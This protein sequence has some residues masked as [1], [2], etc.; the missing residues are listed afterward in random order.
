MKKLLNRFSGRILP[1]TLAVAMVS[2]PTVGNISASAK[3]NS[4]T[5]DSKKAE[6]LLSDIS[7]TYEELFPVLF[8]K[9]YNKYWTSSCEPFV[10]KANANAAAK[11]LKASVSGKKTGKKAI[12]YYKKKNTIAFNCNFTKK[13]KKITFKKNQITGKNAKGKVIFSHKYHFVGFNKTTGSYLYKSND[14]KSGE[15]TYFSIA[16]DTPKTTYHTE[17]RYGSS[18]KA[19]SQFTSG[20]YAYWNVGAIPVK[21]S[22]KLIKNVIQLFCE[23]NLTPDTSFFAGGKGTKSDPYRIANKK[24][25]EAFCKSVNDGS[26]YGYYGKYIKLTKDIDLNNTDW[27]PIGNMNDMKTHYTMFLGNFDGNNHTISNVKFT[28]AKDDIGAGL[29]GINCGTIQNLKVINANITSTGKN[30]M[31]IGGIVGYNMGGTLTNLTLFGNSSVTGN[32]CVGGIVG[33]ST[34]NITNATASSVTVTVIGNNDF[35]KGLV[36]CDIAECGGLI[37][38]GGFGGNIQNCTANG[39]IKATGNEPVG[40]GGIGGCLE[41]MDT[42][43]NCQ[44]TVS[45]DAPNGGH[46]IG[47]ICGYAGTHSNPKIAL[48]SEGVI[49]TK[50][51]SEISNCTANIQINANNATH[52]GGIV[53]TGLYYYGEETRFLITNC[54]VTGTINGAVTPGAIAGRAEGSQI[55]NCISDVKLGQTPLTELIGKTTRRYESADQK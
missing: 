11:K 54:S 1:T 21:H 19:L 31:A 51:P 49:T 29:F 25:F 17:F 50:Y 18:K 16:Q 55:T 5:S 7:G 37:V 43:T 33:G 42:V 13:L 52:V 22:K 8:Q 10:G 28:S 4:K 20:K 12:T 23:E 40:L 46:A 24:Q 26:H 6:K 48:E 27:T 39:A 38:G 36:Q 34:G 44:A 41:M 47:G 32:N 3:T 35:S 9:K 53:G 14:K 45:I 15:F 2:F 30:S